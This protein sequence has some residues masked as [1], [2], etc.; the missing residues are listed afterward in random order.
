MKIMKTVKERDPNKPVHKN[1]VIYDII[2]GEAKMDFTQ[3]NP[4]N[5]EVQWTEDE[6]VVARLVN[7]QIEFFN[8][9]DKSNDKIK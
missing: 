3:K 7:D 5:W 6:S 8:I 1:L 2:S 4:K 9:S